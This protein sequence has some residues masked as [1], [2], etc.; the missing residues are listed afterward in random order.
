MDFGRGQNEWASFELPFIY[1]K[2]RSE[3]KF[4]GNKRKEKKIIPLNFYLVNAFVC[5]RWSV[6]QD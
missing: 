6:M 3:I 1:P 2:Q 5:D 4:E